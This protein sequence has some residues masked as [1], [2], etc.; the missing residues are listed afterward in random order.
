MLKCKALSYKKTL[1]KKIISN[2]RVKLGDNLSN[3]KQFPSASINDFTVYDIL[4]S[5]KK[6][7]KNY[8][9]LVEMTPFWGAVLSHA[10][11]P[12]FTL[13]SILR[14]PTG[15][16]ASGYFSAESEEKSNTLETNHKNN[17]NN[18]YKT[19]LCLPGIC[20]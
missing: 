6:R 10:N 2:L 16:R 12:L 13:T 5:N 4:Q 7:K 17:N 1:H 9:T 8:S 3:L 15:C 19:D 14:E 18:K 20:Q 11:K